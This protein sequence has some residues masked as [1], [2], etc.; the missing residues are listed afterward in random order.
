V[1]QKNWTQSEASTIKRR[2]KASYG[3]R[4]AYRTLTI[5]KQVRVFFV[6]EFGV[7]FFST[8]GNFGTR[9]LAADFEKPREYEN[10]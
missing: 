3:P 4:I 8:I 7:D 2:A 5:E 10:L 9:I 1:V 6:L